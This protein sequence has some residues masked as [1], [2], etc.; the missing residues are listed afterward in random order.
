MPDTDYTEPCDY[1]AQTPKYGGQANQSGISYDGAR[2]Q[3]QR[4]IDT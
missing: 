2:A 4:V 1:M 3:A